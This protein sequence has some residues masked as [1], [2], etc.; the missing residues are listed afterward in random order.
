[1]LVV[2]ERLRCDLFIMCSNKGF[3]SRSSNHVLKWQYAID[4]VYLHL[5]QGSD[6]HLLFVAAI[7]D[8]DTNSQKG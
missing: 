2:C 5:L 4:T 8:Y 7:H 6:V 3:V 1:V